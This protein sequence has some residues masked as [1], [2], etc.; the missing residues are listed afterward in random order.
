MPSDTRALTDVATGRS[1]LQGECDGVRI[2][3]ITEPH[4]LRARL[5]GRAVV[6]VAPCE[7]FIDDEQWEPIFGSL[8]ALEGGT[9]L[10]VRDVALGQALECA[11]PE[12]LL[13]DLLVP[14]TLRD[15]YLPPVDILV[16][17]ARLQAT[18]NVVGPWEGPRVAGGRGRCD[19]PFTDPPW[20]ECRFCFWRWWVVRAR[21]LGLPEQDGGRP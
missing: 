1:A 12:D 15:R 11:D 19:H 6:L 13:P 7:V 10:A 9:L 18:G 2:T 5:G 8:L 14:L 3:V 21:A 17:W 16:P 4:P 20:R